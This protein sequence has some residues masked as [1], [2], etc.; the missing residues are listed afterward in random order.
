VDHELLTVDAGL[1]PEQDRP[2]DIE[3]GLHVAIRM[4]AVA[5]GP[6]P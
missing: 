6:V 1:E 2:F 3:R 5:G 4:D